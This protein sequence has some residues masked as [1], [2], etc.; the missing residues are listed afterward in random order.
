MRNRVTWAALGALCAFA[1]LTGA[2]VWA[3]SSGVSWPVSC[4]RMG[5]VN[6]H[7]NDLNERLT[8]VESQLK[9]LRKR[10]RTLN[11]CLAE[12][13]VTKQT[14]YDNWDYPYNDG[15]TNNNPYPQYYNSYSSQSQPIPDILQQTQSG[16]SVDYW[17][18]RDT[19]G[20]GVYVRPPAP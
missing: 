12:F 14:T 19:C 16:W 11:S 17:F 18:V 1:V 9:G 20:A 13:P 10:N 15:S 2:N 6:K 3:A 8:A 5:C 7:L 4:P